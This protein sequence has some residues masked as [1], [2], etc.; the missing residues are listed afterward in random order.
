MYWMITTGKHWVLT[1]I[2]LYPPGHL[3]GLWNM[4]LKLTAKLT[5]YDATMVRALA[6]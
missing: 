6:A 5:V 1:S 4:K 2:L 3:F